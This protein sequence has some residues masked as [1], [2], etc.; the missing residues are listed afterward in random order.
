MRFAGVHTTGLSALETHTTPPHIVNAK[1]KEA[2]K[3]LVRGGNVGVICLGCAAMVG[4]EDVVAEALEEMKDEN[5]EGK[6]EEEG[7]FSRDVVI[8]DGVKAGVGLLMGLV[9]GF[10]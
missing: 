7:G 8:V 10:Y 2:T 1:I 3:R 6:R 9:N 5:E 4:M